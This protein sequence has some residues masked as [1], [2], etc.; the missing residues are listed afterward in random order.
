MAAYTSGHVKGKRS[1]TGRK[2]TFS[3]RLE[4]RE[5]HIGIS[6]LHFIDSQQQQQRQQQ[7]RNFSR[8]AVMIQIRRLRFDGVFQII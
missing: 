7:R 4:G 1:S 3:E 8:W 5:W 6:T 2:P